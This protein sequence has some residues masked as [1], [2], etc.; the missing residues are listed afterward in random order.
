MT[1]PANRPAGWQ[2]WIDRGGTFT[3]IV[4]RRPDGTLA[5]RKLLSENPAQYG[6]AALAGIRELLGVARDAAIPA[7]AIDVVRMGTTVATNALLERRGE[8]VA[9]F[10]TRGFGDA[11]RIAWQNRPRIFD[12]RIVLPELLYGDVWEVDERCGARGEVIRAPNEAALRR[13]LAAA[14]AQGYTAI[15]I[16]FMH[17]YRHPAHEQAAAALAREAGFTQIS[18]SHEVSPLMKLVA[19]GDTTVA[20]AYLTPV[21]R[22][23]VDRV[24]AELPGVRLLFMQSNGGLTDAARFRGRDSILSG[25]AGGIVGAAR[26][27]LAAGCER[28]IG[29]DMGGT[30]TDVAHFAGRD[31]SA[32]ER[33]FDTQ[34]AGVR[35]RAPMLSIHTVAAGGG[36]I[37]H[38]DG[39]RMRVGPDSAGADPGPACYGKGGPATITDC[40]ALLGRIHPDFF[41]RVFGADGRQPLDLA[42]ARHRL[43]ALHQKIINKNNYLQS[44]DAMAEGFLRIAVENMANAI[45]KISVQRGHDVTT[46][47]LACFGGAAGQHACRVADALG[48]PRV[49]IHPLAGVLSAYGMG[50]ADITAMREQALEAVLDDAT[51]LQGDAAI[52]ALGTALHQEVRDQGVATGA[53]TL[54][55]RAHLKYAGTDTTL[56]VGWDGAAA[57]RAAFT[58]QYLER[59]SFLMPDRALVIEAV[60]VEAIGRHEAP[61]AP[62]TRRPAVTAA[63][64]ARTRIH[65]EGHWHEAPVHRREALAPGTRIA[66]PALLADAGATTVVEPG[67]QAEISPRGDLLLTRSEARAPARAGTR[68]DPV[69]LEVF[70]NLYMSIAEQMG[71][72]LA[73]TAH[74]VNIKE[75]LDFS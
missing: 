38:F 66:G 31:L 13:D 18:A 24:R 58:A 36:S 49:L 16:V 45:K 44:I 72:T 64:A 15:A 23:Y 4:A 40:N 2:F 57:M 9:L 50:L 32:L 34:V 55:P 11:L 41:P 54:H 33:G 26:T 74:S 30:S 7:A 75:R 8:P 56:T 27:A 47:T 62:D 63:P 22:R 29:F 70:N 61:A 35:I 69:L 73:N 51:V 14:R 17:G 37:L 12:R 3:D 39:A 1:A 48:M 43:A 25:P 10:I 42:A 5:T 19:R 46:Y 28:I 21:L 71:A 52:A 68:A 20:D 59:Y 53:I 65:A 67:W 6:D 60:S